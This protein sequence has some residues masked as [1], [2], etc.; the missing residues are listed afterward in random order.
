[1]RLRRIADT[2]YDTPD[3]TAEVIERRRQVRG[4]VWLALAALMF[5][6]GRVLAHGGLSSMFPQ[7]W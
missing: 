1:M 6:M 7:G 2:K 3:E 5:A 4:L